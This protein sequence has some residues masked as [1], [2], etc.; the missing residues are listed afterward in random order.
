MRNT[1]RERLLAALLRLE[2]CAP[3]R[4]ECE[5]SEE[6]VQ[7]WRAAG[8]L[9]DRTPE[10]FFGIE[11]G[12]EMPVAWRRI[13]EE[14]DV[15]T[16]AARLEALRRA[17]DPDDP[18]RFP[19]DWESRCQAWR[20]RDGILWAAPWNEGFFQVIGIADGAT[21]NAAL[22]ALR[23]RP[24]LAEAA[25]DHYA[26]F[27]IRLIDRAFSGVLPD[28][29]ELYEPIACNCAPV[30]A[31][32]DYA[33]FVQPAL[34]RICDHLERRGAG[35]RVMWSAGAVGDLVPLWLDAGVNGLALNQCGVAGIQ[36]SALRRRF[37]R[38]LRLIGGIDWRVVQAGPQAI[39]R[40]LEHEV[41]PLLESGGCAPHLD[42]TIR[43]GMPFDHF[44][45]YRRR[46]DAMVESMF[47]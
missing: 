16:D 41:R 12:G 6:I 3:P 17:Y 13:S 45:H 36:Y 1:A 23:E 42:D 5:F 35:L 21:L 46:L 2:P 31:P 32:A 28:Y 15:L 26:D 20:D 10:A 47:A 18:R 38:E 4:L 37:G 40:Y 27:L 44:A 29:V 43:P 19:Q 11:S 9:D 25:M 39:D 7:E 8:H 34:R 14:E 24:A 22:I 30:I 33:R